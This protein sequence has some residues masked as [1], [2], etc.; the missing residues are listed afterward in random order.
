MKA[1]ALPL[2]LLL[3]GCAALPG[4]EGS[5]ALFM[6]PLFAPPATVV[7]TAALF[8]SSEAM[9]AYVSGSLGARARKVGAQEALVRALRDEVRLE[10]DAARTRTAAEAFEART[11]NCLS[12][13]AMAYVLARELDVPAQIQSVRGS[14]TWMR[15]QNISIRSG[16]TNVAVGSNRFE[17]VPGGL[18]MSRAIVDF[19]PPPAGKRWASGRVLGEETVLAM[20]GNNRAAE[21]LI[22]G[23]VDTSYWWARAAITASPVFLPAHNTLAV[24]YMRHGNLPEAE[25]ALRHVL[26]REPENAEALNNL[27]LVLSRQDRAA[28]AEAVRA[29]LAAIV[30]HPPYQYLDEGLQALAR[31]EID[32]AERLIR[33]E[34]KRMPYDDEVNL[35]L[36]VVTLRLGDP[37][38][39]REHMRRAMENSPTRERRQIYSS[40]LKRMQLAPAP[41]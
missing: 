38:A 40:K 19:L 28:E 14:D 8:A 13:V 17:R 11:G 10:Y 32:E 23:D 6:D 39:A 26:E 25:R 29:R 41:R 31:G 2:A 21:V 15:E 37:E 20:Y 35:A 36:A 3:S 9:R 18:R 16:H 22:E 27:I 1:R 33:K 34:L 12:L 24:I 5:E 30:P 7:D 4:G